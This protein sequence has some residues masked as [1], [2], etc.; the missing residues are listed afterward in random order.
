MFVLAEALVR[1]LW[2]KPYGWAHSE[3]CHAVLCICTGK[4]KS[5]LSEHAVL[6]SKYKVYLVWHWFYLEYCVKKHNLSYRQV[7]QGE[8]FYF[9]IMN[10]SEYL[11]W[12][13]RIDWKA[14]LCL[15]HSIQ[16]L[17]PWNLQSFGIVFLC[18]VA[19]ECG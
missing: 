19:I 11:K 18:V 13:I 17:L 5:S 9:S 6:E 14:L 8:W 3:R 12:S 10:L 15:Q 2:D 16:P 1:S 4:T 7:I